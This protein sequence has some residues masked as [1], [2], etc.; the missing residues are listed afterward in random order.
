MRKNKFEKHLSERSFQTGSV[1]LPHAV[2]L[3]M[4]TGKPGGN[5]QPGRDADSYR[6]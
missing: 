4:G 1:G 5:P 3:P 6:F 2:S